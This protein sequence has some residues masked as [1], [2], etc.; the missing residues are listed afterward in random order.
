MCK[1]YGVDRRLSSVGGLGHLGNCSLGGLG[2]SLLYGVALWCCLQE[3]MLCCGFRISA[4]VALLCFAC[5]TLCH[6]SARWD[7]NFAPMLGQLRFLSHRLC[8]MFHVCI[9]YAFLMFAIPFHAKKRCAFGAWVWLLPL[10][11]LRCRCISP[12][13]RRPPQDFM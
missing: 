13:L 12:G 6:P 4:A 2:D 7:R 11:L 3:R 5:P 10:T 8:L 1:T 9:C